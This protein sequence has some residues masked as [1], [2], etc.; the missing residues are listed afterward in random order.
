MRGVWVGEGE[1]VV[2]DMGMNLPYPVLCV[3]IMMAIEREK[4]RERK[5]ERKREREGGGKG[6]GIGR[7]PCFGNRPT[8]PTHPNQKK[9]KRICR[10]HFP[11]LLFV[12]EVRRE[13]CEENSLG[14]Q[15]FL[16]PQLTFPEPLWQ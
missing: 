11:R 13:T 12:G 1:G 6:V 8:D 14:K 5:R 15:R 7:T 3:M 9:F 4:E 16:L 10:A 2:R